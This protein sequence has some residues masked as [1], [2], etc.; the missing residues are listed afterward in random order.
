MKDLT[1]A[2]DERMSQLEG[3]DDSAVTAEWLRRQLELTLAAWAND[4]T[5]LDVERESRTDY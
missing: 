4:E 2:A 1:G 5:E 3:L